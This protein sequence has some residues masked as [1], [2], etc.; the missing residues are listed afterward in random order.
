MSLRLIFRGGRIGLDE[1]GAFIDSVAHHGGY[2]CGEFTKEVRHEH[3]CPLGY[4]SRC[5]ADV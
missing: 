4:S 2:I 1:R 3:Q 5:G